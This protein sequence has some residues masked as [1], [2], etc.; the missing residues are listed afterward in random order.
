MTFLNMR[1]TKLLLFLF[2][3]TCCNA[4]SVAKLI[5]P[6][7]HKGPVKNCYFSP[8]DQYLVSTDQE[9][10]LCIWDGNNGRQLFKLRDTTGFFWKVAFNST[11]T[12]LAAISDSTIYLID[13]LRLAV[14][15]T[16]PRVSDFSFSPDGSTVFFIINGTELGSYST[17]GR[18]ASMNTGKVMQKILATAGNLVIA[19][20]DNHTIIQFDLQNKKRLIFY[21][22]PAHDINLLD[23]DPLQRQ[24]LIA[25]IDFV[26]KATISSIDLLTKK[27][28]NK[29][30]ITSEENIISLKGNYTSNSDH[31]LIQYRTVDIDG[32]MYSFKGPYVFSWKMKKYIKPL[33]SD[34][35][36]ILFTEWDEL[37]INTAKTAVVR[38]TTP[39][40]S[41]KSFL[42][43]YNFSGNNEGI[44]MVKK[45]ET[46]YAFAGA[47]KSSK[48]AIFKDELLQPLIVNE[49]KTEYYNDVELLN[50]A[51]RSIILH[52]DISHKNPGNNIILTGLT[53]NERILDDSTYY[54]ESTKLD[55]TN[56]HFGY[57]I[58]QKENTRDSFFFN[59][60]N[61]ISPHGGERKIYW[62]FHDSSHVFDLDYFREDPGV[63]ESKKQ[64]YLKNYVFNPVFY[65]EYAHTIEGYSPSDWTIR[66]YDMAR[67]ITWEYPFRTNVV[68]SV[69]NYDSTGEISGFMAVKKSPYLKFRKTGE[70]IGQDIIDKVKN[71]E[72]GFCQVRYWMKDQYAILSRSGQVF[73]YDMKL[74]SITAFYTCTSGFNNQIFPDSNLLIVS[75]KQKNESS[76]IN[77]A[78]NKVT[79]V[80]GFMPTDIRQIDDIIILQDASFGN[81]YFYSKKDFSLLCMINLFGPKDYVVYTASGLF[82]GTEKAMENLYFLVN[83]PLS[84]ENPWKTIDLKQLKAK[85]YTP[86]L[87]EKLLAGDIAD[88][89]DVEAM[90]TVMLAP[91][92]T[93]D[94][95]WSLKKPFH[96]IVE[97]KGGGIGP[98]RVVIN[99]KEV[100]ADARGMARKEAKRIVVSLDLRPYR[101][102]FREEQNFI[103]V[104]AMNI[105][106]S[107][108]SRGAITSSLEK[109]GSKAA[110]R[111]FMISIGT[112]DYKGTEIDLQ[113][114]SKDAIDM[115]EAM[116][117][118]GTKLFGADSI[119]I[120]TLSSNSKDSTLQPSKSNIK[121][122]FQSVS[123]QA[124]AKDILVVY[125]SGHGI[126]AGNDFHYLTKDAW[127]ANASTYA[128]KDLLKEVSVSSTEFTEFLNKIPALKQLVI[129]DACASGKLVENLIAHRDIPVSTLK[130]LDRMKDRTGT[131][132]I[133]GCAADAVSYEA[134][135]FGQGL[136]TYSLLE[137]MKGASLRENRF[138][139]VSQWF[140]YARDRVPQLANGLGGIQTPQICSPLNNESFDVAEL[141]EKEK[142][143]IPLAREK[144]VFIRSVFQEENNFADILGLGKNLDMLLNE[145]SEKGRESNFLYIPVDDFP[146]SFQVLGRYEVNKQVITA[147]I[148]I[149]ASTGKKL[150]SE[151]TISGNSV[152][153]IAAAISEKIKEF[154]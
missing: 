67:D 109:S 14:I 32:F 11:S 40:G 85:Y 102:Y 35:E 90:K 69:A 27:T 142:Q 89:P 147:R 131:H 2:I 64:F 107:I 120:Y 153:K 116:K 7:G 151:F 139:D 88:L 46:E 53:T 50:R 49:N 63:A 146:G 20:E 115:A 65:K 135:R 150:I 127:S 137:G 66:D 140:Q 104:F 6:V 125:L 114:S 10:A 58:R 110:P 111:L 23:Y 99:G 128:Y 72:D 132:V 19:Q 24:V 119:I 25:K 126:N 83:D 73:I 93:T 61:V 148:K 78:T 96:F 12:Q 37:N 74:D 94:T 136:L 42:V 144:P 1:L 9:H 79:T 29:L 57:I 15:K 154:Q 59:F 44:G 17:N 77:S 8:N 45:D 38:K 34:T 55:S 121:K 86:S 28:G 68:D 133:T 80:T 36:E 134:S 152:D 143:Q 62:S 105:D 87:L 26:K 52:M 118:G 81:Y 108:S 43:R 149:I 75:N 76:F 16:I 39:P 30:E 60:D 106:S 31:I 129:I 130:A 138:L 101:A 97:D 112:S 117:M 91:E 98:V 71:A 82:D 141:D 13:F 48:V 103:Q 18:S 113:Y 41:E 51:I 145:T 84:K 33:I 54:C 3:T 21:R 123:L 5:V 47:N 122:V 100:I 92:I 22:D 95:S 56:N 4:Q 70:E 124:R